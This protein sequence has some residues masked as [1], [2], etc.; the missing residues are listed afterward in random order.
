[1]AR[2]RSVRS[3][4]IGGEASSHQGA[5]S[6]YNQTV[7]PTQTTPS[8]RLLQQNQVSPVSHRFHQYLIQSLTSLFKALHQTNTDNLSVIR[9]PTVQSEEPALFFTKT[10]QR[11]CSIRKEKKTATTTPT[12][13]NLKPLYSDKVAAKQFPQSTKCTSFKSLMGG[14]GTPKSTW[15]GSLTLQEDMQVMQSFPNP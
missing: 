13:L 4:A 15:L 3:S 14:K 9:R 2:G 12:T 1:M 11:P 8:S 6:P 7:V 5:P 10:K